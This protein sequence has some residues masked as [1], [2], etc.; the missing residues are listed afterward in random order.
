MPLENGTFELVKRTDVPRK[1][2]II[3]TKLVY[4]IKQNSDHV[5]I[6]SST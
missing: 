6:S 1:Q 5:S 4:K 2:R 3:E